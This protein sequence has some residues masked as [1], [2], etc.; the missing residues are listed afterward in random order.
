MSETRAGRLTLKIVVFVKKQRRKRRTI[1]ARIRCWTELQN[2][3]RVIKSTQ[4]AKFTRPTWGPLGSG[5]PQVRPTLA[6]WTLLSGKLHTRCSGYCVANLGE[7]GYDQIGLSWWSSIDIDSQ[8]LHGVLPIYKN[9]G[10][11]KS[12]WIPPCK[13]DYAIVVVIGDL[14]VFLAS[15]LGSLKNTMTD[16]RR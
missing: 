3:T 8:H 10:S 2:N 16:Q 9:K 4:I 6:P 1:L 14:D 7:L 11:S 15:V 12:P 13:L 5:R